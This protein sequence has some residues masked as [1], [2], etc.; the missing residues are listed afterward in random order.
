MTRG[1]ILPAR[2]SKLRRLTSSMTGRLLRNAGPPTLSRYEEW[3]ARRLAERA[4]QGAFAASPGLFSI[5]TTVFDTPPEFVRALADS[6]LS[7]SSPLFEWVLLDNGSTRHDVVETVRRIGSDERVH[8]L[9]SEKNLG[10]SGG[11]RACLEGASGA[12]VVPVDSDDVVVE[13]ALSLLARAIAEN[14]SPP[15][16]YTDEDHLRDGRPQSPY[17]RPDWDPVLNLSTSYVFHLCAFRRHDALELGVYTDASATWCHDWDTIHRF[18][19]A[20]LEPFH[21]REVAYHW[22]SH[23]VSS[24]NRARPEGGSLDS[25]RHVLERVI[26]ATDQPELFALELFPI[27]RGA[28]EWWVRRRRVEP[29]RVDVVIVAEAEPTASAAVKRLEDLSYPFGRIEVVE[30]AD[31]HP[32]VTL[33]RIRDCVTGFGGELTVVLTDEVVPEGEEWPWEALGLAKLHPEVAVLSPRILNSTRIVVAGAEMFGFGGLIGSPEFARAAND[34]GY[35]ALALKQRC[36]SACH[37]AFFIARTSFLQRTL[38]RLPPEASFEFLGAWLGAQAADDGKR[39]AASPLLT[40]VAPGIF[41][42][43]QTPGAGEVERFQELHGHLLSDD[44]WYSPHFSR[45]RG[46]AYEL[47]VTQTEL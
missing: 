17:F 5:L 8:Y 25:Q 47:R 29:E 11:M 20:G 9:W 4:R 26:G 16:V 43:E 10:I 45:D 42:G 7:Q 44:R 14:D 34:P 13:D 3:L 21:V 1:S 12:Y 28:P 24:T 15:F 6:L 40:A 30:V 19:G 22:R 33:D 31:L 41:T 37:S 38:A 2:M 27:D 23:A 18:H 46:A 35:F 39:V 36:V 32:R